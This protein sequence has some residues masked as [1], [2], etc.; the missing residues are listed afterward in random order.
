MPCRKGC[1]SMATEPS[2]PEAGYWGVGV[3]KSKTLYL[4]GLYR[5]L[6]C[7]YWEGQEAVRQDRATALSRMRFA[8][9]DM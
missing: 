4:M 1:V 7:G 2:L 8:I 6:G 9:D 5:Y 3:T